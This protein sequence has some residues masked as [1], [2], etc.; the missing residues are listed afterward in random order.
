MEIRQTAREQADVMI[1]NDGERKGGWE[2]EKE[3][4]KPPC[5][6]RSAA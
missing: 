4:Q 6:S 3:E 5:L 2:K 1:A